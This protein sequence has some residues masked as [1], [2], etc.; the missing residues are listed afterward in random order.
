MNNWLN[1]GDDQTSSQMS[2][3][4]KSI[5]KGQNFSL[6]I[7]SKQVSTHSSQC[8]TWIMSCL[9]RGMHTL[10]AFL[11]VFSFLI[12]S[13]RFWVHA[14]TIEYFLHH[15]I[16]TTLEWIGRDSMKWEVCLRLLCSTGCGNQTQDPWIFSPILLPLSYDLP[17]QIG[18]IHQTKQ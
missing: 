5:Q 3:W 2:K 4:A 15:S 8:S 12:Y 17:H 16:A 10:S 11:V 9:G 14:L 6:S 7:K 1:S 18:Y 13:S